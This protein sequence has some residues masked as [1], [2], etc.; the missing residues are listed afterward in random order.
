M[1]LMKHLFSQFVRDTKNIDEDFSLMKMSEKK[2]SEILMDHD[3]KIPSLQLFQE[4]GKLFDQELKQNMGKQT[5]KVS[6]EKHL[7]VDDHAIGALSKEMQIKIGG[8]LSN[9]MCKNLKYFIGKREYLLLKPQVV[10]EGGKKF[11]GY[12]KFNKGFVE[13]FISELDK[14]HDLNLQIERSLPMIYKPAPWKNYFFGGYYL[15]QTKLAKVHPQFR[16]AL[17]YMSRADLS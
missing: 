11:H 1:H 16:E 7:L 15:K 6:I 8:F 10:R 17:K 14:I 3:S 13:K 9:L 5:E 2:Q 4:L 12:I